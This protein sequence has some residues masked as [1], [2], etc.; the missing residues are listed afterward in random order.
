MK[1]FLLLLL[2]FNFLILPVLA[3]D[4]TLIP[5][6]NVSYDKD[7]I[8]YGDYGVVRIMTKNPVDNV[9][10]TRTK[11]SINCNTQRFNYFEAKLYDT[12]KRKYVYREFPN[13]NWQDIPQNSNLRYLYNDV[14]HK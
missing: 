4:W 9:Y 10:E 5:N 12:Y 14:C 13:S 1:K 11:L 7:S 3:E 2:L 6:T 8:E